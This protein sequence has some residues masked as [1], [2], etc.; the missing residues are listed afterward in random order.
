MKK[1]VSPAVML[2]VLALVLIVVAVFGYRMLG[3]PKGG[4]AENTKSS[5]DLERVKAGGTLYQPPAGA[6]VPGAGGAMNA[7]PSGGPMGGP[8]GGMMNMPPPG[9]MGGQR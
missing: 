8:P 1:E 2:V 5:A 7:G 3:T 9:T 4:K 6:P